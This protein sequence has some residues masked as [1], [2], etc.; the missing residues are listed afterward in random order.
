MHGVADRRAGGVV[1]TAF[2]AAGTLPGSSGIS[3]P[4]SPNTFGSRA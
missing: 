1:A 3:K 2:S 4:K